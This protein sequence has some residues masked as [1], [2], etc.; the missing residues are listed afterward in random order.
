M[1]E[2]NEMLSEAERFRKQYEEARALAIHYQEMAA[3]LT[4]QMPVRIYRKVQRSMK[5]R[6]LFADLRPIVDSEQSGMQG[7]IDSIAYRKE[8]VVIRGWAVDAHG[9]HPEILLRDKRGILDAQLLWYPRQDINELFSCPDDYQAGFTIRLAISQL[10][11]DR[12]VLEMENEVGVLPYEIAVETDAKKRQNMMQTE[13]VMAWD[14][15]GY[16]DWIREHLVSDAE[17]EA[18]KKEKFPYMPL[19]SICIPLYR[20]DPIFLRELMDSLLGQSYAN[21]E[22]CLADG[23]EDDT[24]Q[25][26]IASE[27]GADARVI[28]R[29]LL[30]N[31]GISENTNAA[32]S[33]AKGDFIL[34]ADHDDVLEK[35]ACYE[36]V[37]ALNEDARIDA[38]YTD[39]DKLMM[40]GGVYYSPNFKPDL[41]MDLLCSN[42]YITHIFCVRRSIL[43]KVGGER[44]EYDGAQDYDLI[45]RCVEASRVVKHIPKVLY[46]WRAHPASTAGNPESKLY[47][48][49][50]GRRAIEAHYRRCGIDASVEEA[51]QIGSYRSHYRIKGEPLVSIIIPNKDQRDVLQRAIDSIISKTTWKHYELLIVENNSAE[52]EIFS[53]YEELKRRKNVRILTYRGEFN[54]SAIN[55]FAARGAKGEYLL[56]LNNDTEVITPTWIEELLGYCQREDVGAVGA[57]LYYPDEHLQHCGIVVG[58]GGVAGHICHRERRESGGYFGRIVKTQDVSAVT[59]ACMM[60]KKTLFERVGG[61]E[62]ALAVAYNDVDYC[63][64]LRKE[65]YCIVYDAWALLYHYESVSR[66][67]DEASVNAKKHERQ[68][69]EARLFQS[70]W[71]EILREGDPYFNPNLDYDASD[72]V[73]AGT[74]PEKDRSQMK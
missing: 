36:I 1:T 22:I 21:I 17:L 18:Q 19:I 35:N 16:D 24:V 33:M 45:L 5:G 10:H 60:T 46:H 65:G 53:Y 28:Y 69:Q 3:R 13:P 62:E 72:F 9:I 7:H 73:L 23:S 47:A 74:V 31:E 64:K 59:G 20:T 70:R 34:L 40:T 30:K 66:G 15:A 71:Q 41:N 42:N 51:P 6:D 32:F 68:L 39:E 11:F 27:Y 26:Q 56:F 38:L 44:R 8:Q 4:A 67:S 58:I 57:R 61:F 52:P 2:H 50:N 37:R 43:E 55:N 48:Y 14:T 12:I 25:R 54:Y 49:E 63:L 29:H